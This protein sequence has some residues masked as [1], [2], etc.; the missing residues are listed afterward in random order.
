M[1][2]PNGNNPDFPGVVSSALS[3]PVTAGGARVFEYGASRVGIFVG[4]GVP[5]VS[6]PQ[7]SLY[8]R[9]DGS[10]TTT[11]MYIN[12]NGTTGW[13]AVTTSA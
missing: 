9:T 10:S 4:S 2:I 1:A 8:L 13:T 11:R 3:T 5:T 7:G 12:T 6:A